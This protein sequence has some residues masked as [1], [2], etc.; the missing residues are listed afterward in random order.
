MFKL[1]AF[2]FLSGWT[3]APCRLSTVV[4]AAVIKLVVILCEVEVP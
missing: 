2:L 3:E 4:L 1:T